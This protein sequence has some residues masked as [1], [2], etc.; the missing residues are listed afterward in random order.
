VSVRVCNQKVCVCKLNFHTI[1][2]VCAVLYVD[3]TLHRV[4]L[5]SELIRWWSQT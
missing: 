1:V 5:G 3:T 2:Y 4:R